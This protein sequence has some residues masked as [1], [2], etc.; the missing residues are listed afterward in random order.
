M[1]AWWLIAAFA[2]GI[3][4]WHLFGNWMVKRIPGNEKWLDRTLRG[5]SSEGL[6]KFEHQIATELNRRRGILS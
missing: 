6:L 5:I 3:F 2:A 1:S 4:V